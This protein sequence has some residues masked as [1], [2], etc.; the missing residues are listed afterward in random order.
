MKINRRAFLAGVSF[1]ALTAE[2]KSWLAHGISITV[3]SNV[4]MATPDIVAFTID[5]PPIIPG[6]LVSGSFSG[7]AYNTWATMV[8]PATGNTEYCCPLGINRT[9]VRFSDKPPATAYKDKVALRTLANYTV[10]GATATAVYYRDE[11]NGQGDN[12]SPNISLMIT[13][14][15]TVYIKLSVALSNGTTI[16]IANSQPNTFSSFSFTYNDKQ[17]RAGGIQINQVGQRPDDA[18]RYGYLAVRI[19]GGSNNGM[20]DFINTHGFTSFQILNSS[21]VSVFTGSIVQR[22]AGNEPE[23][24]AT[25]T[26][27]I[28]NNSTPGTYSGVPGTTLTVTALNSGIMMN[29]VAVMSTNSNLSAGQALRLSQLSGTTNGVGAYLLYKSDFTGPIS[30]IAVPPGA[31]WHPDGYTTGID[32]ADLSQGFTVTGITKAASAVVSCPGHTLS[33]GDKVR[34][35]GINGM[36]QINNLSPTGLGPWLAAQVTAVNPGVSVTINIDSTGFSTFAAGTDF[37][38]ALGGINNKIFKCFNTNRAGTFTFGLDFSGWTPGASGTYYLH[39]PGYG[40]SDPF[41]I[42][43]DAWAVATG[44]THQGVFNQRL[45]C[46]VNSDNGYSRG[47]AISDGVNGCTNYKS[48]FV[49][50]FGSECGQSFTPQG[51]T[52]LTAGMGAYFNAGTLALSSLTTTGTTA[53]ATTSSP[54][55]IANGTSFYVQLIGFTPSGYN[56]GPI[57]ATVTGASTFTFAVGSTLAS[58]SVMGTVR[59]GFITNQRTGTRGATQDAGDNDDLLYDHAPGYKLLALV[60]RNIPK[61]SRFTPYVVPLS[62]TLLNPTL[63]AGTD[64][65]PPLFHELFW[66]ADQYRVGQEVDGSVWGGYGYG[67][68]SSQVA[69]Y[70]ETIDKYRGTDA[71]GSLTGQTVMGFAYARDHLST[72]MYAGLA[73]QLAQIAYDYGLTTLGNTWRDSAIAAYSWADAIATDV[74]T[75]DAHYITALDL[76]AKA[77]WTTTQYNEA[78]FVFNGISSGVPNRAIAAKFDAAGSL[79]RLLGSVSGQAPYGNFIEKL[80]VYL[81]GVTTGGTNYAVNDLITLSGGTGVDVRTQ[82][83]VTG[84]GAGGAVTAV[85]IMH[86]GQY[87]TAPS[88][89]QLSTT[90]AGTGATFSVSTTSMSNLLPATIGAYDYVAT[91]GANAT[92]KAALQAAYNNNNADIG[93]SSSM[94]YAGMMYSNGPTTSGGTTLTQPLQAIQ[95]HL[96]YVLI[97]GTGAGAKSS[98]YIKLMQAGCSFQLGANLPNKAFQTGTGPRPYICTLHEDAFKYGV[99]TPYGITPYG[100]FSYATSFMFFNFSGIGNVGGDGP[101]NYNSD[102]TG[103]AFQSTPTPG[104]AKMWNPWR[105]GSSYW[106]WAPENRAII[107]NSEW[108]LGTLIG[109]LATQLY[110]HGWDGNV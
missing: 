110:L 83:L 74:A 26:G 37:S 95:A 11:A 1:L 60:F 46:A 10:T 93:L 85:N 80:V 13:Q 8:N 43:S 22:A 76:K 54:H 62:T 3:P 61:L 18:L 19:P 27:Y 44:K 96:N 105:Y 67:K 89:T 2:A 94:S 86:T 41:L 47:I 70:P 16:T 101:L 39:I 4:W 107:F 98:K 104:S 33:V 82:L 88:G 63:Y 9:E 36:T 32:V 12:Y 5:D 50:I 30:P 92:I 31:M 75:C 15:H 79:Y 24:M 91:P 55:G 38:A 14:R 78:M 58:A 6:N 20:V 48:T 81:I 109:T 69:D 40:I 53:T 102:N 51:S 72:F 99:G 52:V 84:I 68:F 108:D 100:Y 59:S 56:V 21:K 106:E 17:V 57:L 90:G 64:A 42:R 73:A 23:K 49:S 66:Y 45:G 34:L 29:A 65:L 71:G 7:R 87:T 35:A 103:G 28:D 77:G 25:F 97:N